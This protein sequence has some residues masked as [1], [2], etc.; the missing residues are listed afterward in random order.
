MS[1]LSAI[2]Q[3]RVSEVMSLKIYS[4]S[5][6]E[7]IERARNLMVSKHFGGLPVVEDG[8]CVG[9]ITIKDTHKEGFLKGRVKDVMTKEFISTTP[10]EMLADAHTKMTKFRVM[11]LPV[12]TRD[13]RLVGMLT[14]TDIDHAQKILKDRTSKTS[15]CK[16]CGAPLPLTMAKTVICGYCQTP[17]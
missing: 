6:E 3:I 4:I 8:R 11:R 14:L 13:N 16:S 17:N 12:I 10:E 9:I 7:P 5:P 1:R 15:K 2:F